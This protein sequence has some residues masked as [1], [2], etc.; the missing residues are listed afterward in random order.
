[1]V[2]TIGTIFSS[3]RAGQDP[4][5]FSVKL[6]PELRRY[7]NWLYTRGLKPGWFSPL[8]GPHV[9]FI[10]GHHEPRIITP[11]EM[12]PWLDHTVE[13][14][15]EQPIYTNGR[16]F[17][18]KAHSPILELIRQRLELPKS[19]RPLHVTLGTRK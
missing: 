12:A 6:D 14:M 16:A 15:F 19:Q 9:T 3:E 17:W 2:L 13:I 10:F 18:M 7:Y 11:A 4:G 1:M 5:W 8:N